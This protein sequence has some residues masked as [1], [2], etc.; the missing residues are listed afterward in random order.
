[1][2]ND[3]TCNLEIRGKEWLTKFDNL[4]SKNKYNIAFKG[5]NKKKTNIF[6]FQNGQKKMPVTPK[7]ISTK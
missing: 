6:Y 3:Y 7:T 4:D 5:D 2:Q 1:M